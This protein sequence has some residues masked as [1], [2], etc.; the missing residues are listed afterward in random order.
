MNFFDF[1][2]NTGV[3]DAGFFYTDNPP[4]KGLNY[5]ISV[6]IHLSEAVMDE[7][8][9]KPTFTYFK[10][11]KTVNTFID[12]VLLKIGFELENRGFKYYPVAASQSIPVNKTA[13]SSVFSHKEGA[14]R[15]GLGYIG[16]SALFISKK[17]GTRVR[18]GTIFT[19]MPLEVKNSPVEDICKDCTICVKSCPAMAIQGVSY[20]EGMQRSEIFDAEACSNFMKDNF[21][22]IGRGSVCGVCVAVCPKSKIFQK[23]SLQNR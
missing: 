23:N 12:D 1:I 17:Y 10:H 22:G 3:S 20:R 5:G 11:Y 21:M 19:D 18:L 9:D 8:E 7:I 16:K 2:M 15:A 14:R 6:V 13:Y 4:V